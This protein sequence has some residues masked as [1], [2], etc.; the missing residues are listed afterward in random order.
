MTNNTDIM[1]KNELFVLAEMSFAVRIIA[2]IRKKT[3]IQTIIIAIVFELLS[4]F[5]VSKTV[6]KLSTF[7]PFS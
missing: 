2:K 1:W 4:G 5:C 3:M 7:I 6:N